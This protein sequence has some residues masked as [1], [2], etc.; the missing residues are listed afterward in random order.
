MKIRIILFINIIK[1]TEYLHYFHTATV[2]I[3]VYTESIKAEQHSH[4]ND[5]RVA[6]LQYDSTSCL[7]AY[8]K[9]LNSIAIWMVLA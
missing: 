7:L 5:K 2:S 6:A 1:D 8:N 4:G 3:T 9:R